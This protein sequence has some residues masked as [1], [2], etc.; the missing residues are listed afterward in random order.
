MGGGGRQAAAAARVRASSRCGARMQPGWL[1][2]RTSLLGRTA[3]AGTASGEKH[4][5]LHCWK[6]GGQPATELLDVRLQRR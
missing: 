6:A 1:G 4:V 2:A 3:G 5:V